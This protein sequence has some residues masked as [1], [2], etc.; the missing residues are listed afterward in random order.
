MLIPV[1]KDI[2]DMDSIYTLNEVGAFIWEQLETPCTKTELEKTIMDEFDAN[3]GVIAADLDRFLDE[4]VEINAIQEV[5][6]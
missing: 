1:H 3:R 2:A 4:M 5:V 6:A